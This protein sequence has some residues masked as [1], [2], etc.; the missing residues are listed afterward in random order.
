MKKCRVVIL[1][2]TGY[3]LV[4]SSTSSTID[5]IDNDEYEVSITRLTPSVTEGSIAEFQL[6]S[7]QP[8]T[9][10]LTINLQVQFEGDFFNRVSGPDTDQIPTGQSTELYRVGTQID[11][12][13]ENNGKVTVML[14][15]GAGYYPNTDAKSSS[16]VIED[17][18]E[19]S[20]FSILANLTSIVEGEDAGFTIKTSQSTQ[21][22]RT[23]E[24]T[25]SDGI[26]D[27]LTAGPIYNVE[28]E[29]GATT[30]DLQV[31]TTDDD[32]HE[33]NGTITARISD[34]NVIVSPQNETASIVVQDNDAQ[35]IISIR[36]KSTSIAPITEGADVI[37]TLTASRISGHDLSVKVEATE[38][39]SNWLNETPDANGKY[40]K[41]VVLSAGASNVDFNLKT[42]GDRV[43][44]INGQIIAWV[45]A[46]V[47]YTIS[48]LQ[49]SA[50]VAW[51]T[52]TMPQSLLLSLK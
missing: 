41:T 14:R 10:D 44:E 16:I 19:P 27:F 33:N 22:K 20:G 11:N 17:N 21:S 35:P 25:V 4:E 30:G 52:M 5:V 8:V 50:W 28:I 43:D 23:I 39:N 31:G 34:S 51:L 18:D 12:L 32:I 49:S 40:F 45:R 3:K 24:V 15:P 9:S 36:R 37:F 29:A 13:Y 38:I 26:G 47:G 1:E 42:D 7:T 46:G 6:I 2:G 48:P